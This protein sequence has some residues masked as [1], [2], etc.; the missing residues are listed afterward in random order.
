MQTERVHHAVVALDA[1]RILVIGGFNDG[2]ALATTEVLDLETMTF[3][4]GPNLNTA[5]SGCAA[6]KLIEN[7]AQPPRVLV[8]G[9]SSDDVYALKSTEILDLETMAFAVGP[10]M[11]SERNCCSAVPVDSQR[12]I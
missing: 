5:R 2:E 9:G 7:N 6:V 3:A 10:E 12:I 8:V 11:I 4:L 1:R